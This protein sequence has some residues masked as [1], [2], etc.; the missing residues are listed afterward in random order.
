MH[1][2]HRKHRLSPMAPMAPVAPSIT[3]STGSTGSTDSTDG[4]VYTVVNL[5]LFFDFFSKKN[6]QV[7]PKLSVFGQKK[8][9]FKNV[10]F[11]SVKVGGPLCGAPPSFERKNQ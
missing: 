4:T 10:E 8:V 5:S 7:G 2:Q 3:D 11:I 1:R 9:G 6:I